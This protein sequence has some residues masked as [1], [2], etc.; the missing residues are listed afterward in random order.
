MTTKKMKNTMTWYL[1]VT[2]EKN[3]K[4]PV[5]ALVLLVVTGLA[6]DHGQETVEEITETTET[7]TAIAGDTNFVYS[8]NRYTDLFQVPSN[9]Q[10]IQT[11]T[12]S[13]TLATTV[14]TQHQM[15]L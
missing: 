3:A 13:S 2:V 5:N 12:S 1:K 7:E 6:L 14:P 11:P 4:T 10:T 15:D 8:I 9:M